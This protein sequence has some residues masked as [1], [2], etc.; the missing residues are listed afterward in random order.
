MKWFL[1]VLPEFADEAF[2]W[3]FHPN[4]KIKE[5]KNGGLEITMHGASL[6]ELSW[7]LFRWGGKIRILSP[8]ALKDEMKKALDAGV[9]MLGKKGKK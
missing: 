3:Q 8:K 9:M 7:V 2:R 1:E 4:Q 6:K 5:L